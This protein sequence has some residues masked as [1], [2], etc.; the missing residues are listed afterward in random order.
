MWHLRLL[1]IVRMPPIRNA[2]VQTLAG[3]ALDQW[4]F[5]VFQVDGLASVAAFAS[6][7]AWS[8]Y[9]TFS[10]AHVTKAYSKDGAIV[11]S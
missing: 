7:L 8:V 11:A 4:G 5:D 1:L 3:V 6:F 10:R 2:F 9:F